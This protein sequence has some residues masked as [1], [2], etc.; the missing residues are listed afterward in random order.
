MIYDLLT[1]LSFE[2]Y[3]IEYLWFVPMVETIH[4]TG[5][6][7][8]FGCILL[9]DARLLGLA[10]QLSI[11][12]FERL[13]VRFSILGFLIAITSGSV[14]LL[15]SLGY[16]WGNP[17]LVN[18]LIFMGIALANIGLFHFFVAPKLQSCDSNT[19]TPWFAKL[20]ALTS[21]TFWIAVVACGRLIA[22][23]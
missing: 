13:T 10:P 21:L 22:Y 17:A 4:Y 6:I 9:F 3:A 7:L 2:H 19:Q 8:L 15:T 16:F 20:S 14:L 12:Q 1:K 23:Y 18:K 5:H 11:S